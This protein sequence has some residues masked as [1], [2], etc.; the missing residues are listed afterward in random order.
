M[1]NDFSVN[2]FF[3]PEK[4]LFLGQFANF[5]GQMMNKAPIMENRVFKKKRSRCS[6]IKL[7]HA[8][9]GNSEDWTWTAMMR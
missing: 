7:I 4:A 5:G 3:I 8:L 6:L 9:M 2:Y 1:N